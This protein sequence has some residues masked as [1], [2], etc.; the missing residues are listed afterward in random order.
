MQISPETE[1]YKSCA[2]DDIYMPTYLERCME[3]LDRRPEIVACHSRTLYINER[4]EEIM[5]SFRQQ[6]FTDVRPWVRLRQILLRTH[7]FPTC[8]R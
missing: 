6:N 2:H 8:S 4:S 3:E 5:R 1:F 7:D